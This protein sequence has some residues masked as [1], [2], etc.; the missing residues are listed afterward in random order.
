MEIESWEVINNKQILKDINNL[1]KQNKILNYK[2]NKTN[3]LLQKLI[4]NLSENTE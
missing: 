2:L 3:R 4:C 1:K